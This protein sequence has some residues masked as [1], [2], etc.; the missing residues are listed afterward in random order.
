MPWDWMV[1]IMRQCS[2]ECRTFLE[3]LGCLLNMQISGPP[4]SPKK[5]SRDGA[6]ESICLAI[7]PGCLDAI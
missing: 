2:A 5:M 7:T 3:S 6:K 4:G 1:L